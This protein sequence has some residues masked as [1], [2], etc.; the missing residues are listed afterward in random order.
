ML[1]VLIFYMSSVSRGLKSTLND[2]FLRNF[3][4]QFD[5]FSESHRRN[6][7]FNILVLFEMSDMGF[8]AW[9]YALKAKTVPIRLLRLATLSVNAHG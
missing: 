5:L 9:P 1:C 8:E 4:S 7:F 2:R 6:I 3:S